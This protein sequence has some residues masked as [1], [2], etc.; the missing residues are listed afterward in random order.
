LILL[1]GRREG[2][3][4]CETSCTS[5]FVYGGLDLTWSYLQKYGLIKQTPKVVVFTKTN[6]NKQLKVCE[7]LIT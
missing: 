6:T 4:A 7:Q 1:V 2:H 5:K 3:P